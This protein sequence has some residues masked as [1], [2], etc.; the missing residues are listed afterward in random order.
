MNTELLSRLGMDRVSSGVH[1]ARLC[2][3]QITDHG[4]YCF[5]W[6]L[7]HAFW[8]ISHVWTPYRSNFNLNGSTDFRGQCPLSPLPERGGGGAEAPP[9]CHPKPISYTPLADSSVADLLFVVHLSP[10]VALLRPGLWT[11]NWRWQFHC[12]DRRNTADC[13]LCFSFAF[14]FI[15][16]ENK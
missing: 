4:E 11:M 8:S 1:G 12:A 9:F 3:Y 16:L 13:W 2:C 7:R 10:P 15:Q 6:S 5:L 14:S